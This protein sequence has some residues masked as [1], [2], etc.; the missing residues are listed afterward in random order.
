M[1][2][3]SN[4][5]DSFAYRVDAQYPHA[6][7]VTPSDTVDLPTM[8][9][10]LWIGGAGS[11]NLKVDTAGG[12]TAVSLSSVGTGLLPISVTRVYS[13]GTDVTNIVAIW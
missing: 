7:P 6:K 5:Y 2:N 4:P 3:Q 8:A 9:R 1:V 11:G 12:E 10:A 13:T